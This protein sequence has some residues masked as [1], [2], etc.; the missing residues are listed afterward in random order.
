MR[1]EHLA[2]KKLGRLRAEGH[3][4]TGDRKAG[5]SRHAAGTSD[6]LASMMLRDRTIAR[7]CRANGEGGHNRLPRA[8]GGWDGSNG[9][10]ASGNGRHRPAAHL[11][12]VFAVAP[13]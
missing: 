10:A 12:K 8:D 1:D 7:S 9:V 6:T 13:R 3:P 4:M 5:R 11:C 2:I